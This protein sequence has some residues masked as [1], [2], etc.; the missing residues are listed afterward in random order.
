MRT[1]AILFALSLLAACSCTGQSPAAR[2]EAAAASLEKNDTTAAIGNYRKA[3]QADSTFAPAYL[4]LARIC[5]DTRDTLAALGNYAQ[6]LAHSGD[7]IPV[8][9]EFINA[10]YHFGQSEKGIGLAIDLLEKYPDSIV[11]YRERAQGYY[12]LGQWNEMGADAEKYQAAYPDDRQSHILM[13]IF[14]HASGQLDKA[15]EEFT[16]A[17]AGKDALSTDALYLRGG[18]RYENALYEKAGEDF[19]MALENYAPG[20]RYNHFNRATAVAYIGWCKYGLKDYDGAAAYADSLLDNT[21]NDLAAL[22]I[23]AHS[24]LMQGQYE[25][26]KAGFVRIAELDPLDSLAHQNIE[27]ID[28]YLKRP[29]YTIIGKKKDYGVSVTQGRDGKYGY[30]Y[31]G[32]YGKDDQALP[33][34]YDNAFPETANQFAAVARHGKWAVVY[35]EWVD[36]TRKVGKVITPFKYDFIWIAAREDKENKSDRTPYE[37]GYVVTNIGGTINAQNNIVGGKYGIVDLR[38]ELVAPKYDNI[39]LENLYF[40][41]GYPT[42]AQQNGKWGFIGR[43]GRE[44]TRFKYDNVTDFGGVFTLAE[45]YTLFLSEPYYAGVMVGD[46][47]KKINKNGYERELEELDMPADAKN[48]H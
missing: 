39:S 46:K 44:V 6:A 2:V 9:C 3:L 45:A 41:D 38:G 26:A 37:Y 31:C 27:A 18:A 21:P 35:F 32:R 12:L 10:Y 14:H 8:A 25:Q 20:Q 23:K 33:L 24:R 1:N 48:W 43:D 7:S 13:G 29:A 15:E 34:I 5:R 30:Y 28:Q 42:P 47:L 11:L 36:G 16:G 22:E 4:G 19:S 17:I 40:K